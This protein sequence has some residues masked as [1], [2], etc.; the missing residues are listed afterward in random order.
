ML[1]SKLFIEPEWPAPGHIKA[2]TT[3]RSSAV[4]P[5]DGKTRIDYAQLT[6]LLALPDQPIWVNQ[7]HS[8]IVLAA[9]AQYC[10]K[11]ADATYTRD[12]ER[13]CLVATA[14]CLPVLV[15]SRD[16]SHVAAIHAGWRG[17]LKGIIP[18]SLQALGLPGHEIL[19]WLGPAIS[20]PCYE[21]GEEVRQS[22][23]KADTDFKSAFVPSPNSR[24]L[25]DLYAIARLQL[26]KQGVTQIYGGQYCTYS[27]PK[28]FFSYRRD[29]GIKGQMA[30]L[31][32]IR[33]TRN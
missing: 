25:L 6:Q 22:F 20:Q 16:G 31:I 21:V 19:A 10:G 4:S 15:T 8:D 9:L 13:V 24:W 7:T 11:E 28:N 17:L 30:T 12:P 26:A 1:T 32:W 3:L 14:D 33:Q 18:R 29:G 5:A 2:Y 27:D 23:I